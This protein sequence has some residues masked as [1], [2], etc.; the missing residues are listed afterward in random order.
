MEDSIL[1]T[2]K[3]LLGIDESFTAFDTDIIVHINTMLL[4]LNQLKVGTDDVFAISGSDET[5]TDFLGDDY[6][7]L[8]AAKTYIYLG[9]RSVFDPPSSSTISK[10]GEDTMRQLE[11]RMNLQAET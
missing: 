11:W 1:L 3:K 2:I 5:W 8:H 4:S 6:K 9:V 7:S 10:A